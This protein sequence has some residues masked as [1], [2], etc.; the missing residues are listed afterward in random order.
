[1]RTVVRKRG[2]RKCAKGVIGII[3]RDADAQEERVRAEARKHGLT[4]TVSVV[5]CGKRTRIRHWIFRRC[6][7]AVLHFWPSNG[8]CWCPT[9]GEKWTAADVWESM[10]LAKSRKDV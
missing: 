5:T 2:K 4:L 3:I 1:M 9:T 10:T 7:D 6:N 8:K